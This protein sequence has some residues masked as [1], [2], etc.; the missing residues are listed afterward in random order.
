MIEAPETAHNAHAHGTG[1]RWFDIV[2]AVAILLVSAG[3]LFVSLHTG[4]TME[5]LVKENERL[6]R[7]QSTPILQFDSGNVTDSGERALE[8]TITNVGTGPA[9]VMWT[10][11]ESG[12]KTYGELSEFVNDTGTGQITYTTTPINQS[13]LSQGEVRRILKWSYPA[14]KDGQKRWETIDRI[15]FD[16]RVQACYCSVFNECWLSNMAADLPQPVK[17]CA[18]AEPVGAH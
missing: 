11:L 2:M 6:V 9:R 12:G 4:Q 18:K 10:K 1:H 8:F 13:V 5:A 17:N 7:A 15:R 3:S 14:S 16:A